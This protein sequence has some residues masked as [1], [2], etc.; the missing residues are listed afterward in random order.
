MGVVNIYSTSCFIVNPR[1]LCLHPINIKLGVTVLLLKKKVHLQLNECWLKSCS[2]SF[3]KANSS[4]HI[5]EYNFFDANPESKTLKMG[6]IQN[7][8][9]SEVIV[10]HG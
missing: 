2:S 1:I 6:Q 7:N 10:L 3:R 8:S 9:R 5:V 4:K